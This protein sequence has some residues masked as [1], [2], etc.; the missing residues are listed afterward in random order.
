LPSPDIVN[1]K[2]R[3]QTAGVNISNKTRAIDVVACLFEGR[4]GDLL[5]NCQKNRFEKPDPL[6]KFPV[7]NT[8]LFLSQLFRYFN[9]G[10]SLCIDF[11]SQHR[12]AKNQ[13]R[14]ITLIFFIILQ[15]VTAFYRS[16]ESP[17]LKK[18]TSFKY[19][20]PFSGLLALA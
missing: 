12:A 18:V 14:G 17:K 10:D 11:L 8:S 1:L 6:W 3:P 9:I 16:R 2:I 20:N 7:S 15:K 5:E 4:T 19:L 13:C